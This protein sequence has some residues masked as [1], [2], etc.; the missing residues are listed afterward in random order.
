MLTCPKCGKSDSEEKFIETFCPDCYEFKI[1]YPQSEEFRRCKS[2]D[3]FFLKGEW[4]PF[5]G[6]IVNDLIVRKCRG[7]FSGAALDIDRGFLVFSV[8][9][10]AKT[11]SIE[12]PI[13]IKFVTVMCPDCS[14]ISGGYY[15]A[16]VQLRGDE[17]KIAKYSKMLTRLLGKMTF[18]SKTEEVKGG[19]DIYVGSSIK[20]QDALSRL[21]LSYLLTRKLV[22]RRDGKRIYRATFSVRFE[23]KVEDG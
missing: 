21:G 15:E 17:R 13:E 11:F 16:I 1:R 18:I 3:R 9:K 4:R 22:G 12:K 6:K 7:D 19:I 20:T 2:C 23:Y 14:K 5:N 10:G 8:K